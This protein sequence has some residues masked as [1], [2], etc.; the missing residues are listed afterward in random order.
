MVLHAVERRLAA[1]LAADVVGYSRLMSEREEATLRVLNKHLAIFHQLIP[2]HKGRIF[3]GAGDSVI[4]EFPSTVEAVR[5]AVEIQKKLHILN[6]ETNLQDQMQFRIGINVGDVMVEGNNLMGNGVNV[7]ARLESLAEPGGI[8]ISSEVYYQVRNR[9]ENDFYF[10]GQKKLKN[11]PEPMP[12]YCV[13]VNPDTKISDQKSQPR[14][15]MVRHIRHRSIAISISTVLVILVIMFIS[16]QLIVREKT[17]STFPAPIAQRDKPAIAIL[18]FTN[19]SQDTKQDFLSDGIAE[20]LITDLTNISSIYVI[21]RDSSFLYRGDKINIQDVAEKLRVQYILKGQVRKINN[22][23]RI[24]TQ[25]I[26]VSKGTNLWAG[27]Y[28]GETGNIFQL[29]DKITN[30]LVS[31][32]SLRLTDKEQKTLAT[33]TT[34][35]YEAYQYFLRGQN[36]YYRHSKQDILEARE[37]YEK[38]LELDPGFSRV[39]AMYA[40]TYWFEFANG[41]T[42]SPATSLDKAKLYADKAI[43]LNKSLPVAYFVRGLVYREQKEYIK[44]MAEAEHAILL[45]PNYANGRVLLASI[46]YYAGRAEEG[47]ALVKE[48]SRLNPHHPHN[49]PFHIGQAY[50]ILGRYD[51]AAKIFNEGLKVNPTSQRMRLWLVAAYAQAGKLNE[52]EW[53]LEEVKTADE[54][55]SL[56]RIK[57]AYPFRYNADLKNFLDGLKKAG[58]KE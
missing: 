11:I 41:W 51:E 3:G 37:F 53:E 1:I 44:A 50:Y 29:Q 14:T 23:I 24:N 32:L 31:A 43:E 35:N 6:A 48:A 36:L 13:L 49:Y 18:P 33:R 27:R 30:N 54:K 34:D 45:D 22:L 39:Y 10:L 5:C 47:L 40:S 52:A 56:Q 20:D 58:M 55:L 4:A 46:L 26:D 9:V 2:A 19:L 42:D 7:A 15:T 21:A 57:N 12:V 8:N 25:L 38:A 28:T 17:Q 16:Q